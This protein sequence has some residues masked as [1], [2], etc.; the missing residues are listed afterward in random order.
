MAKVKRDGWS[1]S[2]TDELPRDYHKTLIMEL[3]LRLGY[4]KYYDWQLHFL[5][6][7]TSAVFDP[8]LDRVHKFSLLGVHG[9]GKSTIV[10]IA[11]AMLMIIVSE[12]NERLTGTVIAITERQADSAFWSKL[13]QI[14]AQNSETFEVYGNVFRLKN[15]HFVGI[16]KRAYAAHHPHS[17]AGSHSENV[18]NIIDEA[19]GAD[20]EAIDILKTHLTAEWGK[21]HGYFILMGNPPK[22][23]NSSEFFRVHSG[24]V[25]GYNVY[26]IA[27]KSVVP[28]LEED[29]YTQNVIREIRDVHGRSYDYTG[30]ELYKRLILGHLPTEGS[31][32]VFPD[33]VLRQAATISGINTPPY[34]IAVDFA[35]GDDPRDNRNYEKNDESSL[36]VYTS[37][38]FL[39]AFTIKM[40]LPEFE[41]LIVKYIYQ[42]QPHDVFC[43]A[44]GVGLG[45]V[46]RLKSYVFKGFETKVHGIKGSEKAFNFHRFYNK[47]TENY[48]LL[49]E[50]L[51][52]RYDQ[53]GHHAHGGVGFLKTDTVNNLFN[54]L[55]QIKFIVR[56]GLIAL[57]P[58]D[59]LSDSPDLADAFAIAM[60]YQFSIS[61][62]TNRGN[63][64]TIWGGSSNLI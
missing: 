34:F 28:S 11:V 26:D 63:N 45:T 40:K 20:Q 22:V 27:R 7:F 19:S 6:S 53:F 59:T 50:W 49:R 61:S 24:E 16:N 10:A 62:N 14:Q 58:K 36:V 35:G 44:L 29:S 52:G 18:I 4:R 12:K 17:L 39:E 32:Q 8:K 38:G 47:R 56:N 30:H 55:R 15:N 3:A 60:N 5:M 13:K 43:D 57:E 64:N 46:Q 25:T 48:F 9:T 33:Y 51:E 54:E 1:Y 41:Q 2:L 31:G 23:P 21:L 42:Y 37:S